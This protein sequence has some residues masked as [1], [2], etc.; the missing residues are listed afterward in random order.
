MFSMFADVALSL[1]LGITCSPRRCEH[2]LSLLWSSA[3]RSRHCVPLPC[4]TACPCDSTAEPRQTRPQ[5]TYFDTVQTSQ[6]QL[7][8]RTLRK[9]NTFLLEHSTPS[10]V[11]S[12]IGLCGVPRLVSGWSS[13]I[14]TCGLMIPPSVH[15]KKKKA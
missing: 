1:Q 10:P 3:L 2:F 6:V 5:V 11:A 14:S 7:S 12:E 13:N 4:Q 15:L 9:L 8:F